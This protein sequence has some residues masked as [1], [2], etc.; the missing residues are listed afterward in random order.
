M[1]DTWELSYFESEAI[2][3]LFVLPRA[4]TDAQLPLAISVP[5]A[6]TRVMLGHIEL[7]SAHQ[8]AR[9]RR[10]QEL[11]DT[12]F[13]LTPLYAESR[14]RNEQCGPVPHHTPSSIA[15]RGARSPRP[16]GF[17]IS[18]VD[19]AMRLLAHE[20]RPTCNENAHARIHRIIQRFS[21][22]TAT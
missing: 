19:S 12:A 1:L 21:A 15:A 13:E 16:C 22:C 18:S 10:L 17:T 20:S 2:R 11:P 14:R 6:I 4:W 7:V 5:A 3:V 8:R 9:L